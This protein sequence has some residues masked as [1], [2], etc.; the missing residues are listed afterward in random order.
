[1]P[2]IYKDD[3]LDNN[4]QSHPATIMDKKHPC[5]LMKR[6]AVGSKSVFH[7][8]KEQAYKMYK[9]YC[10]GWNSPDLHDEFGEVIHEYD[11]KKIIKKSHYLCGKKPSKETIE[12]MWKAAQ[13]EKKILESL[14]EEEDDK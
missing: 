5:Y 10:E 9:W 3:S 11:F 4:Q 8:N 7:W 6:E 1:M 14:G 12:E 13:M 2:I